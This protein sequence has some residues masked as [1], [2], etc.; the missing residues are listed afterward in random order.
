MSPGLSPKSST[1]CSVCTKRLVKHKQKLQCCLCLHKLHPKCASLTPHDVLTI[2]A[3]GQNNFWFCSTCRANTFPSL[4]AD[5]SKTLTSN[6]AKFANV[7]PPEQ[8]SCHTCSK[9]GSSSTLI[10][11]NMCDNFSHKRCSAGLLGCKSCLRAVFP[12][13]DCDPG[14]LLP[15]SAVNTEIFNPYSPTSRLHNLGVSTENFASDDVA[16]NEQSEMLCNCT[17]TSFDKIL[18]SRASELK[19]MSLNVQSLNNKMDE[20]RGRLEHFSKF[21]I[22]CFNEINCIPE[23]LPFGGTELHL[24]NFHPPIFQSPTRASGR[25]GG[26]AIYINKNFCL[27]CDY[28]VLGNLSE[29]SN[30]ANGEYLFVEITRKNKNIV[31]G[32]M[33]RSPSES[34]QCF[35]DTLELKLTSLRAHKNKHV[36]LVSDSNLDLLKFGHHSETTRYVDSLNEHGFVPTISRPTRITS[37]SATII[38]HIFVNTCY[39]ITKS[40]VLVESISDHLPVFV[41][42][43]I[44]PN[45]TNHRLNST[46]FENSSHRTINQ[47]NLDNFKKDLQA[48]D[49]SGVLQSGSADEKFNI[50]E[51]IYSSV[52]NK[53]FPCQDNTRQR[54]RKCDKVWILPWLQSACDRKNLLYKIF[55]KHPTPEND[56]KYRDMKKFVA[57]HVK[58]AKFRHYKNYFE[59]YSNDSRKQWQMINQLLHRKV[60]TKAA[61]SKI[62][63][64]GESLTNSDEIASAFNSF[65]CNIAQKLKDECGRDPN[66]IPDL[67][68][69]TNRR[70]YHE[71]QCSEYSETEVESTLSS[72]KNKA[73]SDTAIKALKHVSR[74]VT[75]LLQHLISSSLRQGIFP[76]KLKCAKVIPLHKGGSKSELSNYRPISLLSCFSKLYEKAMHARL[77]YFL[78]VNDILY[79]SQYGFRGGHSCEHAL[80]EAQSILLNSLNKK[81]ITALLLI[82]FSK[83]FDMVDHSIL[84]GKLEHYGIRGIVLNWFRSYLT[85]RSQ[86]V[87]VNNV[88]SDIRNLRHG[89]PQGSIL[90]PLL[91]VVYIN[92]IP[93]INTIAKFILYADDANIIITANSFEEIQNKIE[94]LLENL[95]SWVYDNGLK[96]NI[97]K[98]K[99]MIF[100]NRPKIEIDV[101]LNGTLIERS[102]C[103]R[104]LGVLVDENL[105]WSDHIKSLASKIS[106][107]SG[108]IYKLKG[109]VPESVLKTLYNSFIQSNLNYCSSVW[110]LRSKNSVELLFRAQKKA[111]RA[112]ENR[113]N[114]FFYNKDT[115]ECP[116]HT[117]EI[118][119]RNDMLT[120]HNLIAKNCLAMMQRV[121][122]GRC[123]QPIKNLFS[124]STLIYHRPRRIQTFFEVPLNRLRS[125]DNAISYKGPKFYNLIVNQINTQILVN[126]SYKQPLMQHKFHDPFKKWV[127]GYLLEVQSEGDS[128]WKLSNFPLYHDL[129]IVT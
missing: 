11:C 99:Y 61:I 71:M 19:V 15:N 94:T 128:S 2:T 46:N 30:V 92:D 41:T 38:D 55:V 21:D 116:C 119:K 111:I 34:P 113:F 56:K 14:D 58:L 85:N 64:N 42:L 65:F 84:L 23:N 70:V 66:V 72:L 44:D 82:D 28:K 50:F 12:G 29:N 97:K 51:S 77:A 76:E 104:F 3:A 95:Q 31:I 67:T 129:L 79:P 32:N 26:L 83:A 93:Q 49:W 86:Y 91:F 75:P 101:K 20:I 81:Q 45:C 123:P 127:K 33:Y 13:Q 109:I 73:T 47:A 60:K 16:W 22:I 10:Q 103:E 114:R 98:T 112:I 110:G 40:G 74:E 63:V 24:E 80:L 35:L 102:T 9:G 120:V 43:L 18:G 68:I 25:G 89:V 53:N 17:Y 100:T 62:T 107:N 7:A 52:Y 37:H 1:T 115:G 106:R 117:K 5:A 78:T 54:R 69:N 108:I 126:T 90:G 39:A 96:L 27:E 48:T 57:K 121:Y 122:V 125:A 88:S 36:I 4:A 105:S 6:T 87:H 118:F 8:Q 59:T 124:K